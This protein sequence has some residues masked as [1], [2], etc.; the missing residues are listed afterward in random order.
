MGLH[1]NETVESLVGCRAS[2]KQ[3]WRTGIL[4]VVGVVQDWSAMSL[5]QHYVVCIENT[6][7]T[8]N[9]YIVNIPL[10]SK[11]LIFDRY[12]QSHVFVRPSVSPVASPAIIT[13]TTD[14]TITK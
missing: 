12:V 14:E 2:D 7:Y 3:V 11:I 9:I 8:Y 6:S 13:K 5:Y 1:A 10:S 4:S